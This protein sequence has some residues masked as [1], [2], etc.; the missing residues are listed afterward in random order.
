[1]FIIGLQKCYLANEFDGIWLHQSQVKK[2]FWDNFFM[3][4]SWQVVRECLGE[5]SFNIELMRFF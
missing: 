2:I 3:F 4:K 1:M 5:I